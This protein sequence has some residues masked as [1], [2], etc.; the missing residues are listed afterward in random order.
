MSNTGVISMPHPS[1]KESGKETYKLLDNIYMIR[2]RCEND[3]GEM[4]EV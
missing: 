3:F 1:E 4:E 2:E